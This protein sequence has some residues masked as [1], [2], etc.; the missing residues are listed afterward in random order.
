MRASILPSIFDE[1]IEPGAV[2]IV[3]DSKLAMAC[4]GCGRLAQMRVGNPKPADSPSWLMTGNLPLIT[5]QPSVNCVGCC[6]WHGYLR[7]GVYEAC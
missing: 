7:N 4:P 6:G 5:L 3:G 2:A 1:V